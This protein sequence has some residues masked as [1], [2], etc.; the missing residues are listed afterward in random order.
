MAT[1]KT[2]ENYAAAID[3]V[4]AAAAWKLYYGERNQ[5]FMRRERKGALAFFFSQLN[6]LRLHARKIR[7]RKLPKDE[8][9]K[10]LAACRKGLLAGFTF[11]PRV[12]YID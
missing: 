1:H 7:R 2:A 5:S 10:L 9:R 11:R 12:E 6:A 4:P 8:E 3:T